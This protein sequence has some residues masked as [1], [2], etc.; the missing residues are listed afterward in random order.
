MST[1][2]LILLAP[3]C[4][5]PSLALS[6]FSGSR[7]ASRFSVQTPIK[8]AHL[9]LRGGEQQGEDKT[10]DEPAVE[11]LA[12][13][14]EIDQ[15]VIENKL[16]SSTQ[17]TKSPLI[18]GVAGPMVSSLASFGAAYGA[19]LQKR[20]IA[21]KSITAGFIFA[22]S[23]YL[24]QHWETTD[25]EKKAIN[26]TRMVVSALVG[27]LYFGPAAHGTLRSDSIFWCCHAL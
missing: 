15:E 16:G 7:A 27:L 24:A 8:L 25:G 20:P 2:L 23:D 22:L 21:T 11:S 12:T 14:F 3:L 18:A 17:S 10:I 26:K 9:I 5:C 6:T 4:C 13:K 19:S 1:R